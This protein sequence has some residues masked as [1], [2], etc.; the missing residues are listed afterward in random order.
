MNK[1]WIAAGVV[2]LATVGW[3]ASGS[4]SESPPPAP[5]ARM[6]GAVQPFLVEVTD[7]VAKPIEQILS[8][9]GVTRPLRSVTL[10]ARVTST[11]EEIRVREGQRVAAGDVIARLDVEDR[12]AALTRAQA[13]ADQATADYQSAEGLNSRGAVSE[14][15]LR[16]RFTQMQTAKADL[17]TAQIAL[18]NVEIR[19]PFDGIFDRRTI[20]IGDRV[21]PDMADGIGAVIDNSKLVADIDVPQQAIGAVKPGVT[22]LVTLLDGRERTGIV[23]FVAASAETETRT[24]RAEIEIDNR[25]GSLPAG[26]SA[27]VML[28]T[29]TVAAH[30]VSPAVLI[31]DDQG[32]LGAMVVEDGKAA[33]LP[34]AMVRATGEGIWVSGLPDEVSIVTGGQGFVRPGEP[35]RVSTA[36]APAPESAEA[37]AGGIEG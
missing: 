22:A 18:A 31:L 32:R 34:V 4:Q 13:A 29:A 27:K 24:F 9:P 20:E 26:M 19:A 12:R 21:T 33:F 23:T 16:Q 17:E 6:A 36:P 14:T 2:V 3:F 7:S 8:V 10:R 25:D 28:P 1:S 11:V 37:P 30:L 5:P 35:V 15:D